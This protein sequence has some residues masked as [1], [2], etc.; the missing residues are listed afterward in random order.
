ME[1]EEKDLSIL[2]LVELSEYVE[3][4]ATKIE[5]TKGARGSTALKDEYKRAAT[6]YN[7]RSGHKSY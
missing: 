1:D 7:E 4:L 5:Q 3:E 6:E 2:D